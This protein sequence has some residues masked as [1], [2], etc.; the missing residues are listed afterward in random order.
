MLRLLKHGRELVELGCLFSIDSPKAAEGLSEGPFKISGWFYAD[1]SA[2]SYFDGYVYYELDDG[3]TYRAEVDLVRDDVCSHLSSLGLG[4]ASKTG[5]SFSRSF[6]SSGRL[7]VQ[8]AGGVKLLARI[9]AKSS[10]LYSPGKLVALIGHSGM[11]KSALLND[12]GLDR[13]LHDMDYYFLK[14]KREINLDSV[15]AWMKIERSF[16]FVVLSNHSGI[17]K[18]LAKTKGGNELRFV[19]FLLLRRSLDT[20]LE[21]QKIMNEDGCFHE[22]RPD[23]KNKILY[24]QFLK[25]YAD[26]ADD[27]V[28]YGGLDVSEMSHI[29]RSRAV[30]LLKGV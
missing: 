5:F 13:D 29:V 22:S 10:G 23:Y 7:F 8:G 18:T 16:P 25:L 28:S 6:S 17:L 24:F 19:R 9:D 2:R 3:S 27:E 30:S 1:Q 12:L 14:G 11:G 15:V 4:R 20:F 26:L 21:N